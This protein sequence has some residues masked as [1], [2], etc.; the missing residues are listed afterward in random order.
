[1]QEQVCLTC[2]ILKPIH[3]FEWAKDRP[4]P[5][6]HCKKCRYN[7]RD[8]EK[9]KARHREYMKE[10][11]LKEPEK[12]RQNWERSTYGASKEDIIK[13]LG[14]DGCLICGS[15]HRLHIDHCHKTGKVRGLLCS[16]CNTGL[17]MFRDSPMLLNRASEY[18]KWAFVDG[19][20][21]QVD[22]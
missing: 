9:E 18:L 4:S 2:S 19:P 20:H 21:I 7:K 22:R 5:R 11:R 8:R 14:Y 12:V 16:N 6:K 10:R 15:V 1:M 17:G 13:A 3:E